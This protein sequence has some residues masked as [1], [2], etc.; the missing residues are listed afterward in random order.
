MKNLILIGAGGLGREI[1]IWFNTDKTQNI[2][3]KGF[4]DTTEIDLKKYGINSPYLGSEENYNFKNDDCVA[5]SLSDISVRDKIFK[6]LKNK[7]QF[8]NLIHHTAIVS[9]DVKLGKGIIVCPNCIISTNVQ[10]GDITLINIYSSIFHDCRVGNNV[11]I[12]P[13]CAVLGSCKIE[14]KVFLGARSTIFQNST[15]KKESKVEANT[16]VRGIIPSKS[17]VCDIPKQVIRKLT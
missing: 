5:I 17:Y 16:R 1:F 14:D 15:I 12:S 4:L 13:Y 3:I 2:N 9:S 11:V 7:V 6:K 10:I 8:I